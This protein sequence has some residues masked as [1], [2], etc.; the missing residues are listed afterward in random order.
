[1]TPKNAMEGGDHDGD[2]AI[3]GSSRRKQGVCKGLEKNIQGQLKFGLL[4]LFVYSMCFF[5]FVLLFPFRLYCVILSD[6]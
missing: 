4:C 5:V 3:R 6:L 1:M 2:N